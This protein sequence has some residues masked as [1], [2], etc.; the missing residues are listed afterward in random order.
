MKQTP[1]TIALLCALL[2]SATTV[3]GAFITDRLVAGLY[4]EPDITNRAIKALTSGTPLHIIER[5]KAFSKVRLG[6]NTEG[7]VENRYISKEKPARVM[8]LELQAQK[9]ELQNK[10]QA[11]RAKTDSATD[12]TAK[13]AAAETDAALAAANEALSSARS[14]MQALE[15]QLREARTSTAEAKSESAELK[16]HLSNAKSAAAPMGEEMPP[17]ID[18]PLWHYLAAA[19]LLLLGF[20]GGT[21]RQKRKFSKRFGG[22]RV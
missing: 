9:S 1:L 3:Q 16:Q 22:F 8:L 4:S 15:Q 10:L 5:K 18:A 2:L 11:G 6:D 7:W 21:L 19:I 17:L 20:I 12:S 13:A 14:E